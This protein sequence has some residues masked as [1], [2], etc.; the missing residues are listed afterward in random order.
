[1]SSGHRAEQ[2]CSSALRRDGKW[3][4]I[5]RIIVWEQHAYL[6][7]MGAIFTRRLQLGGTK[8]AREKRIKVDHPRMTPSVTSAKKEDYAAEPRMRHSKF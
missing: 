5:K 4:R 6:K 3:L 8:S 2:K 1:M 7:M